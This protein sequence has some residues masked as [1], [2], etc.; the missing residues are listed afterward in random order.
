MIGFDDALAIVLGQPADP[1]E[2]NVTLA[3]ALGRVLVREIS[4]L[5][6]CPPFDKS[7]MD[8]FAMIAGDDSERFT[9]V[10]TVAA[11]AAPARTLHRGECTRIMTGAMLPPGAGR[12]I[13]KELVDESDGRMHPRDQDRDDNVIRRGSSAHAGAPIMR[14]RVLVPQDIG[15]L[16][17][18]GIARVPVA[19]PPTACVLCTGPELRAPG[20]QLGT[21]QIYD[22]N[23]PQLRAQLAAMR[24]PSR[25]GGVVADSPE[26]LAAALQDALSTCELTLL[27]GGVSAGDFD[28]VPASLASIGAEILFHGVAVK[29]GKPILFARHGGS[30]VFGLPGNPV[31]TFLMFEIMVKPFLFRRMG[32]AWDP[33]LVRARLASALHRHS[34]ERTEFLPVR[35]RGGEAF[36]VSYHGSSHVNSLG[37]ANGVLRVEIGVREIPEG[38]VVDVRSI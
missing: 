13:R 30:W 15:I 11:G 10:E 26:P 36:P 17:A 19:V 24:C 12:V 20:E 7:A 18:S 37:D 29:P 14:P 5:V 8:G 31:S 35:V 33:P 6:D 25:F 2:E 28:Y 22:S 38:E 32:L 9:I 23:G 4:S 16:A 1:R 34:A 21:G 27:S 3:D